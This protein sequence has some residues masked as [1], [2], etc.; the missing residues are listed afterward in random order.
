MKRL[1][2]DTVWILV[3]AGAAVAATLATRA[4]MRAAWRYRYGDEPP[5]NPGDPETSWLQ[6]IGWTA[7]SG[8]VGALA[9][10]LARR[11]AAGGWIRLTGRVPPGINR[12]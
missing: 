2:D 3:G 12:A 1:S 5:L 10:L 7:A 6:A 8:L 4:T 11:A 9:A